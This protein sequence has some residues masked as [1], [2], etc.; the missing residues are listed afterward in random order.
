M[1]DLKSAF[2]SYKSEIIDA[3]GITCSIDG[4]ECYGLYGKIKKISLQEKVIYKGLG[5]A[6]FVDK[7]HD[8]SY[9]VN[10][11][12]YVDSCDSD[13]SPGTFGYEWGGYN[14]TVFTAADIGAGILNTN[15]LIEINSRP[16]SRGWYTVWRK[17][18]EFRQNYSDNWFLPSRYELNLIYNERSNLN[19]LSI[20]I[21]PFYWCSSGY[22]CIYAWFQYF[23]K[24]IQ[25]IS[26]MGSHDNRSRLCAQY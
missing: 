19:N 15:T 21:N 18:K 4:I 22:S 11:N 16:T 9:Y 12:D 1:E 10:G 3:K 23:S 5:E 8:L 25:D 26:Y 13:I 24:G 14:T 7:N 6:I 17:I 2:D 20:Q